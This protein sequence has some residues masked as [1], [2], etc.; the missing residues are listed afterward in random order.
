MLW[1]VSLYVIILIKFVFSS[2][3]TCIHVLLSSSIFLKGD[4]SIYRYGRFRHRKVIKNLSL[5]GNI[6]L[7]LTLVEIMQKKFWDNSINW[8]VESFYYLLSYKMNFK[9]TYLAFNL[10]INRNHANSWFLLKPKSNSKLFWKLFTNQFRS[11]LEIRF[12]LNLTLSV[13]LETIHSTREYLP[14]FSYSTYQHI[15]IIQG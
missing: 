11:L 2:F 7:Q 10:S 13:P 4:I 1:S 3:P 12:Y 15:T 8:Q 5:L 6:L 14:M 9:I